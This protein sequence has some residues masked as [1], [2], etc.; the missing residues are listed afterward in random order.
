MTLSVVGGHAA[1]ATSDTVP[2]HAVG[3]LILQ[4]AYRS[5]SAT[6]ATSASGFLVPASLTTTGNTN[7]LK[8]GLKVATGTTGEGGTWTNATQVGT[9]VIRGVWGVGALKVN[10]GAGSG[11]TTVCTWGSLTPNDTSGNNLLIGFIGHRTATNVPTTPPTGLI[12]QTGTTI[13]NY[14]GNTGTSSSAYSQTQTVNANS[15]YSDVLL[16]ITS[17]S[18][19][20]PFDTNSN[21]TFSNKNLTISTVGNAT[22]NFNTRITFPRSS[23]KFVFG[24]KLTNSG[25]AGLVN[26]AFTVT[27]DASID[28]SAN[29]FDFW[30]NGTDMFFETGS[31]ATTLGSSQGWSTSLT[32]LQWYIALDA[33]NKLAWGKFGAGFWNGVS[34]NN[35]LTG[36]GGQSYTVT[37]TLYPFL[38]TFLSG[39]AVTYD[40]SVT[41]L[42]GSGLGGFGSG[43]S[44]WD[45][46][47]APMFAGDIIT[48]QAVNRA[49]TY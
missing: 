19:A 46:Q 15:G 5:S 40:G 37:G 2:G 25:N 44:S 12:N 33:T 45:G 28:Q 22:S 48:R 16:E 24:G 27:A 10:N 17:F 3:D 23:G 7:A 42:I 31:V 43:W 20:N 18:T 6:A 21:N 4:G 29:G 38:A 36:V 11:T 47:V 35:P 30:S 13:T 39:D 26:A 1:S 9:L 41:A 8:V 49:S 32:N 34:T 14:S